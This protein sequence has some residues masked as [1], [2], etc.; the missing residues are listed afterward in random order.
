[1]RITLAIA[2]L[3][4]AATLAHAQNF[5]I[6][7]SSADAGGGRSAGPSFS[8]T[9]TAGQPDG[10]PLLYTVGPGAGFVVLAGFASSTGQ[11]PPCPAD[12]DETGFTDV[13]D[14][15]A[16]V[17]AFGRGCVGPG[18]GAEG[19]DPACVKSADFDQSGFADVD[20]FVAFV[21][22]FERGC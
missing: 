16:F 13:D 2:A 17:S 1:V 7:W 6:T 14:F 5:S 11:P 4:A 15:V 20:D 19:P 22:A 21:R 3:S 10:A 8:V 9:G 18:E 12:F